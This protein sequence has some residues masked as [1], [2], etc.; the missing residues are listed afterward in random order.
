MKKQ[1][2]YGGDEIEVFGVVVNILETLD[3]IVLKQT[4]SDSSI[5]E[6]RF[7]LIQVTGDLVE[8]GIHSGGDRYLYLEKRPLR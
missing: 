6:D 2:S 8:E 7:F 3:T 1:H 4:G 5:I